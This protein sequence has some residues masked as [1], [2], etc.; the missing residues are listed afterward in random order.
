M[1]GTTTAPTKRWTFHTVIGASVWLLACSSSALQ[2]PNADAAIGTGG[3]TP[4]SG[5]ASGH[6]GS[7]AGGAAGGYGGSTEAGG[8]SSTVASGGTFARTGGSA[9]STVVAPATGGK[10]GAT[11]D[12]A[13]GGTGGSQ[14]DA[15]LD[16]SAR[17]DAPVDV[18]DAPAP[19]MDGGLLLDGGWGDVGAALADFCVGSQSKVFYLG[20]TY[21]APATSKW[22]DPFLDCCQV[23]AARVHTTQAVGKDFE[24]VVLVQGSMDNPGVVSVGS[25]SDRDVAS[26]RTNPSSNDGGL[27]SEPRLTG[28]IYVGGK[29]FGSSAWT[30]GAC[31]S[32]DDPASPLAGTRVYV[33]GVPVAPYA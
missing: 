33:P 15:G 9:G 32:V 7:V 17:V 10:A 28:S 14:T 11:S 8:G 25:G 22:T 20:Q 21:E 5:G 12:A 13:A 26:L 2:K 31:V 4:W 23:Y 24:V 18:A 16:A 3:A 19:V 27:S 6:G 1:R 29:P 30:L